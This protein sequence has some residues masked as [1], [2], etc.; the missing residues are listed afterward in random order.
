M[1]HPGRPSKCKWIFS[2]YEQAD[3][4]AT[5]HKWGGALKPHAVNFIPTLD[6]SIYSQSRH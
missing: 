6:V 1:Y 5:A 3:G 2:V 4:E